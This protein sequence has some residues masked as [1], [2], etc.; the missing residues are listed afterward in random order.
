MVAALV[1]P[2]GAGKSTMIG[3]IA[4]FYATTSGR[5]LAL[6]F[7]PSE[8][9]DPCILALPRFEWRTRIHATPEFP[10]RPAAGPALQILQVCLCLLRVGISPISPKELW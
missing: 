1:G 4:V 7:C 3:L 5:A 8:S 9:V 10:L 2:S 6:Q